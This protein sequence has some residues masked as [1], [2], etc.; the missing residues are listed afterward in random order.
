MGPPHI[1][2]SSYAPHNPE[3]RRSSPR[4]DVRT[5]IHDHQYLIVFSQRCLCQNA[6]CL[7]WRS[8]RC[9]RQS[10]LRHPHAQCLLLFWAEST[11][12]LSRQAAVSNLLR[13][14]SACNGMPVIGRRIQAACTALG[15]HI[16]A[17]HRTPYWLYMYRVDACVHRYTRRL[18]LAFMNPISRTLH[19]R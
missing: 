6:C 7:R 19:V 16:N 14:R 10:M 1:R 9:S 15:F 3:R 17:S 13:S 2:I 8:R 11:T 4:R 5:Q 12:H 18:K